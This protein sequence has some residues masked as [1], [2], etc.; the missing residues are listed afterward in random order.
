MASR[1][2]SAVFAAALACL[3]FVG[4]SSDRSGALIEE[5]PEAAEAD[6]SYRIPRGTGERIRNGEPVEILPAELEVRVGETIRIVN[7][8][9]RGHFVGIFFVGAGETVTQRFVS[10]GEFV[11][12]C[13]A[14]P[15][16]RLSLTERD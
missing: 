3:L 13:T 12:N 4:C 5:D 10:P 16:G 6:Y 2:T 9:D 8:D 7:D 1:P 11:G 14:H 15:S